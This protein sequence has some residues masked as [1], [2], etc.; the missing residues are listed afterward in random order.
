MKKLAPLVLLILLTCNNNKNAINTNQNFDWLIGNW[1]RTNEEEGLVTFENWYKVND[2]LYI[3]HG[4]TIDNTDTVWQENIKLIQQ[5]N[6]WN[7]EV[8]GINEKKATI[9]ISTK[10]NKNSF[11]VENEHNDFPKLISY[12]KEGDFLR[13]TIESGSVIVPFHFK[14][15]K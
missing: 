4:F 8:S 9:F 7:F 13:A 2:T 5:N 14:K 12:S 3:G 11:I 10:L 1:Q 15:I 6:H